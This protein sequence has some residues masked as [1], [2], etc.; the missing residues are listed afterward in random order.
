MY[1][2]LPKD[3]RWVMQL[4]IY[5]SRESLENA[6]KK[7]KQLPKCSSLSKTSIRVGGLAGG[8]AGAEREG[9]GFSY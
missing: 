9:G 7:P 6:L 2:S 1:L 8:G 5:A 4:A 3:G